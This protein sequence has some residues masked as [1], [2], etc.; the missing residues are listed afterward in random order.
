MGGGDDGVGEQGE[1]GRWGRRWNSGG[2]DE[3][4]EDEDDGEEY[5]HST[6]YVREVRRLLD[7]TNQKTPRP[8]SSAPSRQIS[9]ARSPSTCTIFKNTT[10]HEA[11]KRKV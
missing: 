7:E 5:D 4:D 2:E 3:E 6:R 10:T 1:R 9:L 11:E 8:N